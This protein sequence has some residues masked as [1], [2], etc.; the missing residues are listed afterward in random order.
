[1]RLK[2]RSGKRCGK[3]GV[4]STGSSDWKTGS[5]E[6]KYREVRSGKDGKFGVGKAREVRS[7]KDGEVRSDTRAK[8]GADAPNEPVRNFVCGA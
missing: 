2:F 6:W 5:S 3:F 7:G 4:E 1:M 8:Y